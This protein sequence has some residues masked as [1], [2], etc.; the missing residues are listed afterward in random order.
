MPVR[1]LLPVVFFFLLV[2]GALAQIRVVNAWYG[3]GK[4]GS[5]VTG[6]VQRFADRERLEFKVSN[7]NLGGDPAKGR[8]KSLTVNYVSRRGRFTDTVAE[9]DMFR[10][11]AGGRP[12]VV[13]DDP[14][15]PWLYPSRP[16]VT[17]DAQLRFRNETGR[18]VNI[19]TVDGFGRWYWVAGISDG[20]RASFY[21][22]IGQ[23]WIATD[24]SGRV[25]GRIRAR[26]GRS[27]VTL[28]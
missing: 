27:D 16:P 5:D 14:Y 22:R 13:I 1:C 8:V 23:N 19:Y 28:D 9:G 17:G 18:A 26:P 2:S 11:R 25:L 15:A 24:R 20:S 4:K 6:R 21:S 3:A 7:D 10:F 12:P